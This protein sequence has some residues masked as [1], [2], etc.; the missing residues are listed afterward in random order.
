MLKIKTCN[1]VTAKTADTKTER[2]VKS[3]KEKILKLVSNH[4]G[5]NTNL[6]SFIVPL[7]V[8]LQ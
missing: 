5:N 7:V 2:E 3:L 6:V 4:H 1:C 8:E